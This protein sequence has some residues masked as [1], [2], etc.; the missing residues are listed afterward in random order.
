M[1]ANPACAEEHTGKAGV[2]EEVVFDLGFV[3]C[4]EFQLRRWRGG[5]H[6]VGEEAWY[7]FWQ[8]IYILTGVRTIHLSADSAKHVEISSNTLHA[9]PM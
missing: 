1:S 9:F 7:S 2:R 3:N 6:F 4:V 5:I 8:Y